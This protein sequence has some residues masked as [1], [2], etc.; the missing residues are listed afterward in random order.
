MGIIDWDKRRSLGM[1]PGIDLQDIQLIG[2]LQIRLAHRFATPCFELCLL[3]RP[4]PDQRDLGKC[5]V[6]G[7]LVRCSLG[8]ILVEAERRRLFDCVI[9]CVFVCRLEC[10]SGRG[11]LDMSGKHL[12]DSRVRSMSS[13]GQRR[14]SGVGCSIFMS[15]RTEVSSN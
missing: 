3:H 4:L 10:V 7:T 5:G 13:S 1:Y 11:S 6:L 9:G 14:Y 15:F 2:S 8:D 12:T